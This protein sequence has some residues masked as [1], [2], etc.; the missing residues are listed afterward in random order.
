MHII[1]L[2]GASSSG[3]TSLAR[4]LQALL[5]D[6]YLYFGIDAYMGTMP[7]RSNCFDGS[8]VCDGFYW[9]DV[10]LPN[11]LPGKRIVSGE[12][13][14]QIEASYRVIVKALLDCGHNLIIDNVINGA[15]EMRVW[16]RLLADHQSCYVG[17]HCSLDKLME[18]EAQRNERA[19]GSAAEQHFRTHVGVEYDLEI[20]TGAHS[21]QTCAKFILNIIESNG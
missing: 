2:N 17:L 18:R 11:N 8:S 9:E 19:I 12:F 20:D 5:A 6:Y 16:K 1:F 15:E 7:E 14:R 3:K 4:E 13:G 21:K 10:V